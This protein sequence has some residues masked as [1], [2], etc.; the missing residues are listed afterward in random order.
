M[1][2]LLKYIC[3]VRQYIFEGNAKRCC[4]RRRIICIRMRLRQIDVANANFI[5]TRLQHIFVTYTILIR[6]RLQL[7][8][9]VANANFIRT[10]LRLRQIDVVANA[11]ITTHIRRRPAFNPICC[12]R[13][14]RS[15]FC[16]HSTS[17]IRSTHRRIRTTERRIRPNKIRQ[18][19]SR[20]CRISS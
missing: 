16:R 11:T 7:Q 13:R 18:F 2:T 10:R 20:K 5:R 17:P 19:P 4:Q 12:T 8:Q 3:Q 15:S 14:K 6:T 9:I 1:I